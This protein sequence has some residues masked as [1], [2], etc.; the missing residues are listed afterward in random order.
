VSRLSGQRGSIGLAILSALIGAGTLGGCSDS[1]TSDV[2]ESGVGIVVDGCAGLTSE[3]GSGMTVE[4]RGQVITAAHTIAGATTITVVDHEG[5]R[6]AATVSAFDKDTD[7]ALLSVP[8]LDTTPLAVGATQTGDATAIVWSSDAGLRRL[9]LDITKRLNVT[10]E[11]IYVEDV[12]Q[13]SA[14]ELRGDVNF[15]DSGGAVVNGDGEIVG[16]IYARS[17]QRPETAF[18]TDHAELA[19]FLDERPLDAT[20]RCR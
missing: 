4:R 1:A 18:A 6:L 16:I 10:I 13:R 8:G 17:R 2:L 3:V 11:D 5:L 7:L 12:V 9:L 19:Q 15:G 14:M 20:A